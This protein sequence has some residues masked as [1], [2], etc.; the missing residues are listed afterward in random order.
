[1]SDCNY[2]G[3]VIGGDPKKVNGFIQALESV[4]ITDEGEILSQFKLVEL[5]DNLSVY[6]F[7]HK[8]IKWHGKQEATW[9][10]LTKLADK[11]HLTWSFQRVGEKAGD[12]E[13]VNNSSYEETADRRL[14]ELF[15][16]IYKVDIYHPKLIEMYH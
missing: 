10:K 12:A 11:Y 15:Y 6:V 14:L 1:M 4:N 9:Q 13:E 7:Y 8:Y 3:A 5:E 2:V 16:T